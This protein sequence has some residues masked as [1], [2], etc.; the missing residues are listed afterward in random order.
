MKEA[1]STEDRLEDSGGVFKQQLGV[2]ASLKALSSPK[3][4]FPLTPALALPFKGTDTPHLYP[5]PARGEEV[6]K[7]GPQGG[8]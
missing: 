7:D 1:I 2:A 5:P 4:A 3:R 8:S 6:G